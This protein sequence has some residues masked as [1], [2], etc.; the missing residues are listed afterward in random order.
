VYLLWVWVRMCVCI[1]A[2]AC[3]HV[4]VC[5]CVSVHVHAHAVVCVCVC[6]IM[7]TVYVRVVNQVRAEKTRID[8]TSHAFVSIFLLLPVCSLARHLLLSTRLVFQNLHAYLYPVKQASG[9]RGRV[10]KPAGPPCPV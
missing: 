3:V 8:F 7:C 6:V 10:H 1:C 2:C 5:M 4:F 9:K